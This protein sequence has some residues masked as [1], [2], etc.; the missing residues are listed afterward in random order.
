MTADALRTRLA[1]AFAALCMS[2]CG[3]TF[4]VLELHSELE[5]PEQVD[6]LHLVCIDPDQPEPARLNVAPRLREGMM[7]P[8]EVVLEPSSDTPEG[9]LLYRARALEDGLLV[10][11]GETLS[12]WRH[13]I[14]NRV[15]LVLEPVE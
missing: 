3:D 11:L 13:D 2:G 6:Q 7:F 14:T 1:C 9:V 10:G 5:I 4:V 15:V 12:A 8:L